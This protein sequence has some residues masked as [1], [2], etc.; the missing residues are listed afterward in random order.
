MAELCFH[1]FVHFGCVPVAV[2]TIPDV[3]N[4]I[5][6]ERFLGC[7]RMGG[8]QKSPLPKIC[9]TYPTM[10]KLGTFLPYLKKIQ[11]YKNHVT[12]F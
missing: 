1:R 11:K 9:P 5:R 8:G 2:T 4:P 3:V 7:S 6:H 12:D 10:V